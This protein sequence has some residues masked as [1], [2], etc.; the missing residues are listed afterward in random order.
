MVFLDEDLIV[1]AHAVVV[2]TAAAHRVLLRRAQSGE[3]LT[4]VENL[5]A[6]T[7]HGIDEAP[8]GGGGRREQLQEIECGA[9]AGQHRARGTC[10]RENDLLRRYAVTIGG[11]PGELHFAVELPE[12]LIRPGPPA[13]HRLLASDHAA[14][15]AL[16]GRH[17]AGCD[18]TA[19]EVL[20]QR[21]F[22]L[23]REVCGR[24]FSHCGRTAA[25]GSGPPCT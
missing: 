7:G 19:A 20:A 18:I 4:C 24:L 16:G 25:R 23:L 14:A 12:G 5:A 10:D 8:R 15:H 3:G 11:M 2:R 13:Q 9:L 22:H 1:E 21:G 6:G 17:Q